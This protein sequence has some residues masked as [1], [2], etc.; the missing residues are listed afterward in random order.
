MAA[1]SVSPPPTP[2]AEVIGNAFVDQYYHI[3]HHSPELVFRF[4][5]D[6]SL[7]SRPE[8]DGHMTT[9]TTMKVRVATTT[10]S[11]PSMIHP[12]FPLN[13]FRHSVLEFQILIAKPNPDSI[14]DKICSLNYKNYKAEIKTANAQDSYKDGVIVLVTGCLTG[15]DGLR[16]KFTQTFF[17]AP[18][19]KGYYVLNDIFRYV[20]EN[21][22]DM[23]QVVDI[24]VQETPSNSL[25]P[26]AGWL[27][28]F[29]FVFHDYQLICL[30]LIAV[31]ICSLEPAEA[32]EPPRTNLASSVM[33]Q[34]EINE[35]VVDGEVINEGAVDGEVINEGVV[36][37]EVINEVVVDDE[38]VNGGYDGNAINDT[39]M[40]DPRV[41]ENHVLE[42][43]ESLPC[44][45]QEDA[46]KK[47]Y[48]SIVS[49]QTKKGP[50]KVY[51]PT[52]TS[53]VVLPKIETQP[54]NTSEHP[55]PESPSPIAPTNASESRDTQDGVE[56]HSVYIRN[57]PLSVTASQLESEFLKFGAIKPHGVQV[58][59]IK[60]QQG[61]CFGFVEFQ[62]F[63]SMQSA[64]KASP[65]TIGD[66]Q[67]VVE[68]KRTTTR[69]GGGRGRFTPSRGGYR[70]DGFRSRGNYNGGRTYV[71]SDSLRGHGNF[72]SGRSGDGY[73]QGRGRGGRR[74]SPTQNTASA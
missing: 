26:N 61:F 47:S 8:P 3:L 41:N 35:G 54:V 74:S 36:D 55:A 40:A 63:S 20:D 1:Q 67:A 19:D 30:S 28:N 56:G 43:A 53:K 32:V 11:L 64:I 2:S 7:L 17:L 37:G 38:V 71:R 12:I 18:Q 51:V 27:Y 65:I 39:E 45:P 72:S 10:D 69:V 46:P 42:A 52:N 70:N 49:S 22:S 73:Q 57:L 24:G 16:R 29:A 44:S 34:V 21:G 50:I 59:S 62:E 14:N 9:V 31:F 66:R 6:T 58:R 5:H 48:A 60:Q 68:I 25:E 13:Q 23:V 33:P 4:Y 15:K